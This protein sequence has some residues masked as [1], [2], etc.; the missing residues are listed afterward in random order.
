MRPVVT[1][2]IAAAVLCLAGCAHHAASDDEA[3]KE[4]TLPP[5]SSALPAS[6]DAK[7]R[8]VLCDTVAGFRCGE[9]QYCKFDAG[10]C[11]IEKRTGVCVDK[12]QMCTQ[13]YQPVCGCDGKTYGNDCTAA[14]KGVNVDYTGECKPAPAPAK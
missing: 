3:G 8:T 10:A 4:V 1:L 5:A 9:G 12:P 11:G 2:V 13:Q 6:P 14:G 7:G